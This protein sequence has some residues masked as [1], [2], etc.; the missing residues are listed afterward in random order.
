MGLGPLSDSFATD[1]QMFLD[2]MKKLIDPKTKQ[3][4]AFY[5]ALGVVLWDILNRGFNI[6]SAV[7]LG[8]LAGLGTL[9]AL[10]AAYGAG[11]PPGA[12][13]APDAEKSGP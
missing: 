9:G 12:P 1:S 11:Q 4:T 5:A 2:Q 7:I 10:A 3:A 13:P 6:Y 8:A